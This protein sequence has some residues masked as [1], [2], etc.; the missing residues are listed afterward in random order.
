MTA[1][2]ITTYRHMSRML[3]KCPE[4]GVGCPRP[5]IEPVDHPGPHRCGPQHAWLATGDRPAH[6]I[7][8]GCSDCTYKPN[9]VAQGYVCERTTPVAVSSHVEESDTKPAKAPL[10]RLGEIPRAIGALASQIA[11]G[12]DKHGV[13]DWRTYSREYWLAKIL[14]H[15]L[16][17]ASGE[18]LDEEGRPHLVAIM[19]CAGMATELEGRE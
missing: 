4:I 13:G 7:G 3:G 16:A 8:G 18:I 15:A 17:A 11:Y 12:G 14:R 5:C 19:T 6:P 9:C 1:S 10:D 2:D